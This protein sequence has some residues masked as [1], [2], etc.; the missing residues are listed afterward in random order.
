MVYGIYIYKA[1]NITLEGYWLWVMFYCS[2]VVLF[3]FRTHIVPINMYIPVWYI[4]IL[5]F[6]DYTT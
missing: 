2:L 6:N 3:Y 5:G 1:A 4:G